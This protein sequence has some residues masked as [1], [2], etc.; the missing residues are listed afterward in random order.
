MKPAISILVV[1]LAVVLMGVQSQA[2]A[3]LYM[4]IEGIEGEVT[5]SGYEGW[6]AVKTFNIDLSAGSRGA[7]SHGPFKVTKSTDK[8]S[9]KLMEA[10]FVGTPIQYL[11]MDIVL[12]RGGFEDNVVAKWRLEDVRVM[13]LNTGGG[14]GLPSEAVEFDFTK[15]LYTYYEYDDRGLV[16]TAEASWDFAAGTTAFTTE[17]EV[18]DFQV[19]NG[20]AVPEPASLGM[21]LLGTAGLLRRRGRA[22]SPT[23]A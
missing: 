6:I 13:T 20:T 19:Y 2:E 23:A 7:P 21:L 15:L 16:G 22:A 12:P 17:G 4:E 9:P 14:S 3:A 8:A 1:V 11:E 18:N 10:L 5:R